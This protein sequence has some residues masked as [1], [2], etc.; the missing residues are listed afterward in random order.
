VR[1][2]WIIKL[3]KGLLWAIGV[4]VVSGFLIRWLVSFPAVQSWLV[5]RSIGLIESEL[6][7]RV[8]IA[9]V[10]VALPAHVVLEGVVLC[11]QQGQEMLNVGGVKTGLLSFSLWE[12]LWDKEKNQMLSLADLVLENPTVH[13]YRSSS[14]VLNAQFLLDTFKSEDT[15]S[16]SRLLGIE[17]PDISI[18]GGAFS[19]KDSAFNGAPLSAPHLLNYHNLEL[20]SVGL[21]AGF[22]YDTTGTLKLDLRNL[23]LYERQ[24]RWHLS[25]LSARLVADSLG[26]D[27]LRHTEV[28][29]IR[30]QTDSTRLLA[31][32]SVPEQELRDILAFDQRLTYEADFLPGNRLDF[33]TLERFVGDTL[34]ITG[35][36]GLAGR[37]AGNLKDL[38]G[39][40]LSLT[41]G[42][43]TQLNVW[44]NM[45]DFTKPDITFL[46]ARFVESQLLFRELNQFLKGILPAELDQFEVIDLDGRFEGSYYD[47][48]ARVSTESELGGLSADLHMTLP[49]ATEQYTYEGKISTDKLN[50]NALGMSDLSPSQSL[51][52]S[53]KVAGSGFSMEEADVTLA[54]LIQY[55]DLFGYQVDSLETDLHLADGFLEGTIYGFDGEGHIDLAT[56]L[57]QRVSPA[58]Y[59]LNGMIK[60]FSLQRYGL[61]EDTLHISSLLNITLNGD[62]L[63]EIL[64]QVNLKDLQFYSPSQSLSLDQL[65]LSSSPRPYVAGKFLK[66][67]SDLIRADISG[68]FSYAGVNRLISDLREEVRLFLENDTTAISEYYREK[69]SD[70]L[71]FDLNFLVE[72]GDS[73]SQFLEL[74]QLPAYFSPNLVVMGELYHRFSGFSITNNLNL[75]FGNKDLLLGDGGP[76]GVDSL[77]IGDISITNP[78]LDLTFYKSDLDDQLIIDTE[79]LNDAFHLSD[80]INLEDVNI[81]VEGTQ[82]SFKAT[83]H[84]AQPQAPADVTLLFDVAFD[85]SGLVQAL[86]DP[87]ST[88]IRLQDDEIRFRQSK[89]ISFAGDSI[90]VEGIWLENRKGD[91]SLKVS[92]VLSSKLTDSLLVEVD[93]F[94]LSSLNE[95]LTLGYELEGIYSGDATIRAG[96]GEV[97][98][99][100]ESDLLGLTVDDFA[101]GDM[102]LRTDYLSKQSAIDA[103]A[104]LF[105]EDTTLI[106]Q[107]RYDFIE[108][109]SP[110]DF[111]ISSP[112]GFPLEYITPF[113]EG[114]LYGID[115]RVGLKEF[116]VTGPLQSP[117]VKGVGQFE[118]AKFGVSYFR[119]QYDV[120]GAIAFDNDRISLERVKL[121]DRN[122]RQANL[123]GNIL[124]RGFQ[125]FDFN[126]Q[127]DSVRHFLLMDTRKQDNELFYGTLY[128]KDA[129]ADITGDLNQLSVQAVASF[130]PGSVLKLPLS[131]EAEFGRPD[132]IIFKGEEEGKEDTRN[133]GLSGFDLNL[134]TLLDENLQ[135]ELIFDERVGDIIRGKGDGNLNLQIDEAGTFSMFGRYEVQQGD[136]LF[137]SQN[138]INKKFTVTPG[139]TI[140]WTGDP[141]LADIEIDARYPVLADVQDVVGS[142]QAVRVPTDVVMLLEGSLEQPE[143]SLSIELNN[144]SEGFASQVVSYVRSIQNDEQELN[145][146]V[147]SLMVFNR[148]APAGITGMDAFTGGIT[149]ISEMLSNQFNYWLSQITGNK[150]NVNVNTSDFQDVNLLVSAKLFNERVT[151][152]R[153]GALPGTGGDGTG[154]NDDLS[155]LI[156]NISIIIRLLP[157]QGTTTQDIRPSEL[158]LEVFNRNTLS[159]N[160]QG[161]DASVQTGLGLFYKK[162]FDRLQELFRKKNKK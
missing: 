9:E 34:P 97:R 142:D 8:D 133:T 149:S 72:S 3:G 31:N 19:Y 120:R 101:Y 116:T 160:S 111:S 69:V 127:V 81:L 39:R 20:A 92:G 155:N 29:G 44:L 151:V 87:N 63:E 41:T 27:R 15:T 147:F 104:F 150:L 76:G 53:G 5:A 57:D 22:S 17:C 51:T 32:L 152:E 136:Y 58:Q 37:V 79:Y 16:A 153:D 156:G 74:F 48:L 68:D 45:Q 158:V 75:T 18:Q 50:L 14:G 122:N 59:S 86:I 43:E 30:L 47:F 1:R 52:L 138:L 144:L 141:Y 71:Q 129:V 26:E 99:D 61:L 84:G 103:K 148:F 13:L 157:K 4:L 106:I 24:S 7:V 109:K 64:G 66:L 46:D 115:G 25:H 88:R 55:S 96:L 70:S 82:R 11:D 28:T 126:L 95:I 35:N 67:D 134:T 98:V 140:I 12:Y 143:I 123:H 40:N 56:T 60:D 21:K 124:H 161:T 113:V 121:V 6:G 114:Q 33:L 154:S 49:P 162:D 36:V 94:S 10:D 89:Y 42:R 93:S 38:K 90:D 128:L 85:P 132:F 110:L 117:V 102:Y 125:Q 131:D 73:L 100:L 2:K 130:D 137:T 83:V 91:R 80:V 159:D 119:T 112:R 65:Q 145:K 23:S 54:S 78:F 62:S 77:K 108:E 105:D 146:Q 107:G 135:V 118:Q 139:G